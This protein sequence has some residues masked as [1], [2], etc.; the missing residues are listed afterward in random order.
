MTK[1][2]IT[3]LKAWENAIGKDQVYTQNNILKKAGQTAFEIE[4]NIPAILMPSTSEQVQSCLKIANEFKIAVYPISKG[5]NWGLGSKAPAQNGGVLIDL[6][7]MNKI[8]DFDED[9]AFIRIQPGVTFQQ[10]FDFLQAEKSDL[11]IDG[12]GSTPEASIIGNTAERGHGLGLYADRFNHVCGL[13]VILPTGEKIHTGFDGF[14]NMKVGRLSKWGVGPYLDGLFTQ[15]NLGIITEMTLWLKPQARSFQ[16]FMF[17]VSDNANLQHLMNIWRKLRLQG[18]QASF[19]IF[20]DYRF[21]AF[22]TQYP[23]EL[24]G[25]KTPLSIEKKEEL[26]AQVSPN[27][28][29]KWIGFGGLYSWDE[30]IASLERK[31]LIQQLSPYCDTLD[32]FYEENIQQMLKEKGE[33][34]ESTADLFYRKSSLR[35]FPNEGAIKMCYWRKKMDIPQELDII[36]DECGVIWYSPTIP[37]TGKDVLKTIKIIE[38]ISEQYG[39]EPNIG[40]LSI[41]ERALDLT[42]AI[43]YDKSIK[44]QNEQAMSC[45]NALFEAFIREGYPPYRLGLQS[46]H[47]MQLKD[48]TTLNFTQ[49]LKRQIDPNNILSRGRYISKEQKL[50]LYDES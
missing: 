21:I 6:S 31:K 41:T 17:H 16:T 39:F 43:C 28:I 14:P 30:D 9:L 5:K 47:M 44:G 20:N 4:R 11:M 46:M 29:G 19:R 3:A 38:T 10:V 33:S 1:V 45:H 48:T 22:S 27:P 8:V 40:F 37:N 35:G 49:Q 26:K 34:F 32:F 7:R 25:G 23:W 24:T 13:E 36:R 42:G 18:L 15:S 50:F 12:I 2:N